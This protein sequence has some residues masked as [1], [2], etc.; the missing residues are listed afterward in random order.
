MPQSKARTLNPKTREHFG[1]KEMFTCKVGEHF[2]L[3]GNFSKMKIA[4][5][6]LHPIIGPLL[7]L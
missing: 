7:V 4:E 3:L 1:K 6:Q 5:E 2:V